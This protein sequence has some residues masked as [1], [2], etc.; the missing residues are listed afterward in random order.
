M[1][2][3]TRLRTDTSTMLEYE[4]DPV[5]LT[6]NTPDHI[7]VSLDTVPLGYPYLPRLCARQGYVFLWHTTKETSPHLYERSQEVKTDTQWFTAKD[8]EGIEIALSLIHEYED[9]VILGCVKTAGYLNDDNDFVIETLKSVWQ[10]IIDTFGHKKIIC[11]SGSYLEYVHL[12]IN[13][14]KIPHQPY[15]K[16]IMRKCGFKRHGNYWVRDG[17]NHKTN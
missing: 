13:Q 9:E 16:K 5:P 15:H 17:S 6:V 3:S 14:K 2:V 8:P 12:C 1:S 4:E 10:D 7:E 11:P